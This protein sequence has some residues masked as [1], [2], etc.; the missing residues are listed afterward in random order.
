MI[1]AY[2]PALFALVGLLIFAFATNPKAATI[3]EWIFLC[4]FL[5]TMMTLAKVTMRIP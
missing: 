3:G 4:G 1:I 2:I 5:V